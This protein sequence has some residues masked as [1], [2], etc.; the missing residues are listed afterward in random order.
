[1]ELYQHRSSLRESLKS[2]LGDSPK[3]MLE[4]LTEFPRDVEVWLKLVQTNPSEDMFELALSRCRKSCDLWKAY[5]EFSP[6]CDIE[7][8]I[9]AVGSNWESGPLIRHI[10][11]NKNPEKEILHKIA[12]QC[13]NR[14]YFGIADMFLEVSD[15]LMSKATKVYGIKKHFESRNL[16]VDTFKQYAEKLISSEF[17]DEAEAVYQRMIFKYNDI[18]DGWIA[19]A[20]FLADNQRM[21]DAESLLDRACT[22][23]APWNYLLAFACAE[24]F[25]NHKSDAKAQSFLDRVIQTCWLDLRTIDA[26][27]SLS[28]RTS[29]DIL[30]SLLDR[31]SPNE[32]GYNYLRFMLAA[33]TNNIEL[34]QEISNSVLSSSNRKLQLID[35]IPFCYAFM[36]L[37]DT[38]EGNSALAKARVVLS[39]NF[40]KISELF[41]PEEF[42]QLFPKGGPP[43]PVSKA[44]PPPR[45]DGFAG[46]SREAKRALPG[47]TPG[48]LAAEFAKKFRI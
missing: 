14:E 46:Q 12:S 27:I 32:P 41:S 38:D 24:L 18:P 36:C 4:Y 48:W 22:V 17:Q 40:E 19:Y 6:E 45:P 2:Q 8:C 9:D 10:I 35:L 42:P 21:T 3:R 25:L 16:T 23:F 20:N 1:M 11:Q 39:N 7:E 33:E 5:L 13:I 43:R 29:A 31:F 37:A 44:P 15:E 30:Q 34:L 28:K 47:Y 26:V